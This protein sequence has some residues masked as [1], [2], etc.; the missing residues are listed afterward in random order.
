M[1]LDLNK[2]IYFSKS[3]SRKLFVV[4][5]LNS[6]FRKNI[7]QKTFFQTEKFE[8][9]KFSKNRHFDLKKQVSNL[10]FQ[11]VISYSFVDPNKMSLLDPEREFLALAN[12]MSSEQSV[13]RSNLLP[14]LIEAAQA[15]K[16]RQQEAIRL[17]ESGM[18]LHLFGYIFSTAII[19]P[20]LAYFGWRITSL[21]S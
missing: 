3:Y 12:P 19:G 21:I 9:K 4:K 16:Y 10:G 15:N 20:L 14:G 17:F 5:K 1:L 18:W 2:N 6:I 8:E 11:E 13:M 7:F